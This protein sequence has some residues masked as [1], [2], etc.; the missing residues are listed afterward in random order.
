MGSLALLSYGIR[1]IG[2]VSI[3]SPLTFAVG[4]VH[5]CLEQLHRVVEACDA[6]AGGRPARFVFLGDY[7]DRGPDSRGVIDFLMRWQM[8]KPD[9]VVCL[10]G[11]HEQLALD[12]HADERAMPDWL[13][14][15]A[16]DTLRSYRRSGGRISPAHLV[17]LAAL[18]LCHDD[19]LRFFVHAGVDLKVPLNE[20]GADVMLWMREPFL[21]R[22]DEVDCGRFIVH[23]HTPQKSGKPDLRAHRVNLDTGAVM[24]GPLTAGVFDDLSAEPLGFVTDRS[25]V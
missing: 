25:A 7:I 19:G 16:A 3:M 11:N 18:P 2:S 1:D 14:N 17:W 5:G 4:D 13:R 15:S 24:G 9:A 6:R 10:R 20:Q 12:A 22:S 23:G 8:A 21:S